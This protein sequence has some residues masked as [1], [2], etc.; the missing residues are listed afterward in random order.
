MKLKPATIVLVIVA[1]IISMTVG[2]VAVTLAAARLGLSPAA[3]EMVR[4]LTS[5]LATRD[6]AAAQTATAV[7]QPTATRTPRPVPPT[8]T[9]SPTRVPSTP[10]TGGGPRASV[11][12]ALPATPRPSP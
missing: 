2:A 11:S 1:L 7:A 3:A 4:P 5:A 8:A 9:P 12:P 6:A 10:I